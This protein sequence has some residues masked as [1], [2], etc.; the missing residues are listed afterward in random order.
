MADFHREAR[1]SIDVYDRAITPLYPDDPRRTA[2]A[3]LAATVD[4]IASNLPNLDGGAPWTGPALVGEFGG[5]F[6]ETRV[7]SELEK[8]L[9]EPEDNS[10]I[11]ELAHACIAAGFQGKY[12]TA[13]NGR[14]ELSEMT[15]RLY[16]GLDHIKGLSMRFVSPQW[17]GYDAPLGKVGVFGVVAL[18]AAG[19]LVLVL[20]VYAALS[21]MAS[22]TGGGA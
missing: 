19:A 6:D 15:T 7:W 14:A 9:K 20:A 2:R 13:A 11:I 22:T 1:A 4:D 18:V 10:D 5:D 17:V 21:M 3:L 16:T 12:R 8:A